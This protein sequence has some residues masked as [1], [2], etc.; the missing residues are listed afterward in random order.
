MRCIHWR[1]VECL[2]GG[3]AGTRATEVALHPE[4]RAARDEQHGPLVDE[5]D[6]TNVDC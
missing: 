1:L 3:G 2:Q 5:D 4:D 6:P